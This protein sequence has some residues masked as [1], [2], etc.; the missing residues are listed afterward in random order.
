VVTT[1]RHAPEVAMHTEFLLRIAQTYSKE[2]A[3]GARKDKTFSNSKHE[4]KDSR[5]RLL[6]HTGPD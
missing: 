1:G 6:L 4:K 3:S 2:G 5:N